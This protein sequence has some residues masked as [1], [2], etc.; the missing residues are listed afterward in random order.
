M[1]TPMLT[2]TAKLANG[3]TM[4]ARIKDK[5][6]CRVEFNASYESI[7]NGEFGFDSFENA[8]NGCLDLSALKEEYKVY[9]DINNKIYHPMG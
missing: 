9:A 6:R 8:K 4:S 2:L 7:K 5:K 1:E 3:S